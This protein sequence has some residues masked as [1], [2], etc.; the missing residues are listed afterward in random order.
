MSTL[1]TILFI[2][3]RAPYGSSATRE[4]LDAALAAAAFEQNVQVLFSGDGV[5]HLSTDQQADAISSKDTSKML[6]ALDYYD[7]SDVFVDKISLQERG[8]SVTPLTITAK[9]IGGDTL[10]QLIRTADCVVAL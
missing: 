6:Q 9:T 5:W 1:K 8:L 4:A 10:K 7:I 2:L 3:Q